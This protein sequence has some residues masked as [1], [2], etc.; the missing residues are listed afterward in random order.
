[1]SENR[2]SIKKRRI[3]EIFLPSEIRDKTMEE[4]EHE[5]ETSG[6]VYLQMKLPVEK[7]TEEFEANMKDKVE[8][9]IL[10]ANIREAD[11]NDLESVAYIHN[12]SWLTSNT[13]YSPI[14]AETLKKIYDYDETVILIAKVYGSD[15]GF[16]L[17]DFEG[18]NNEYGVIAGLGV[19]PRYQRKGLG[20]VIGMAAWNY[21]KKKGVK[22]LRCE[23]YKDNKVSHEFI[24]SLGFQQYD[25]KIYKSEDLED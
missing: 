22:E 3:K 9:N 4:I 6:M 23:V 2:L 20:T 1:M 18:D 14:T 25:V 16:A 13:P 24:S 5:L 17:L 8:K 19:L 21:F 12:R 11:E 15:A 10:R 7:I